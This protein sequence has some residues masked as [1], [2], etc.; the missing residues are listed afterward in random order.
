M[1]NPDSD[2]RRQ[3]ILKRRRTIGA[4]IMVISPILLLFALKSF[5]MSWSTAIFLDL[6]CWTV[7]L[8]RWRLREGAWPWQHYRR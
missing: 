2:M 8:I 4:G 1:A 5:G 7:V 6:L 3:R